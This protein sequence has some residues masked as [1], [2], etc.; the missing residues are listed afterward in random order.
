MADNIQT[1]A[2]ELHYSIFRR[3]LAPT[4]RSAVGGGASVVRRQ[5]ERPVYEF[6][7]HSSHAH[8][9]SAEYIF[10]FAQYHQGDI[11]FWWSGDT[12]GNVTTP[13][14]FG[15]GTGTRTQ[16]FL[17]NRNILTATLQTYTNGVLD[18]P[19]TAHPDLPSGLLTYVSAPADDMPLAATYG[20][21]YLCVFANEGEVLMNEEL[22]YNN[23][24][25]YEGIVIRELVP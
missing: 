11:P 1:F 3:I 17:N 20:C 14:L 19:G 16:F 13:L 22:F 9:A 7:L 5:W 18:G 4:R 23:L 10:Q 8:K 24:F 15:F 21:K 25:R 2:P 12:W 6:V